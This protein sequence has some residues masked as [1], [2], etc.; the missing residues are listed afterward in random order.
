MMICLS[1]FANKLNIF[2]PCLLLF[3]LCCAI[4]NLTQKLNFFLF[5]HL[6]CFRFFFSCIYT[7]SS[8]FHLVSDPIKAFRSPPS[9]TPTGESFNSS[10]I[11]PSL[12]TYISP[13]QWPVVR[14]Q[15]FPRANEDKRFFLLRNTKQRKEYVSFSSLQ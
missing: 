15:I 6:P 10:N 11:F 3:P 12:C 13:K 5:I 7:S 9:P 2:L 1:S 4:E 14:Y 8:N